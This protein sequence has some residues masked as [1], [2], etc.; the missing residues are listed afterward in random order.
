MKRLNEYVSGLAI[1]TLTGIL[2]IHPFSMAIQDVLHPNKTINFDAFLSAFSF[3]HATMAIFFGLLG[4]LNG[5]II[6]SYQSAI[7]RWESRALRLE[8]LLPICAYCKKIRQ[9]ES[10]PGKEPEW[11]EIEDYIARKSAIPLSHGICPECYTRVMK[12]F[13]QATT[14]PRRKRNIANR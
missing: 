7:T 3:D 2:V 1:G 12:D 10:D 8:R 13:K 9:K 11:L 5:L 4:A 6:V 14:N